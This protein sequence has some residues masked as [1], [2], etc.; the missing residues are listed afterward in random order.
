V[1][2]GACAPAGKTG[3][4]TRSA[5][6]TATTTDDLRTRDL[7]EPTTKVMHNSGPEPHAARR[8]CVRVV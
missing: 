5:A 2:V 8:R 7:N 3:S 1:V 4:R 6:I